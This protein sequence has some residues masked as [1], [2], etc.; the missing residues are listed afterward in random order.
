MSRSGQNGGGKGGRNYRLNWSPTL[1]GG[2]SFGSYTI[3]FSWS[4]TAFPWSVNF[5]GQPLLQSHGNF[6]GYS[7]F[8]TL[9]NAKR[10]VEK[11]I[12]KLSPARK[13]TT[14]ER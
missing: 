10:W 11:R 7:R 4:G 14:N 13:D 8:K 3:L 12:E 1:D 5:K 9:E 6:T 2:A